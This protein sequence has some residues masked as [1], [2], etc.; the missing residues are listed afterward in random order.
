MHIYQNGPHGVG[1][2]PADLVLSSWSR[3]LA[4]WMTERGLLRK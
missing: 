2:A 3:R 1:L 4:D